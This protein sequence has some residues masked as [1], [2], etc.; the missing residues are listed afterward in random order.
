MNRR[1]VCRGLLCACAAPVEPLEPRGPC[2]GDCAA[3]PLTGTFVQPLLDVRDLSVEAWCRRLSHIAEFGIRELFLQWLVFDGVSFLDH[4][5]VG[6]FLTRF[7][8]AAERVGMLVH[9]G[10]VAD[11]Q[12]G[13]RLQED[14][15]A[16]A[17]YLSGLRATSL[18]T[19]RAAF[20]VAG[21]SPAFAGWYVPEEIDDVNWRSAE[22]VELL[23]SH[24]T[25]LC[26]GLQGIGGSK[27][28]SVSSFVTGTTPADRYGLF[29]LRIWLEAPLTVLLQDG[30]GVDVQRWQRLGPYA[31]ALRDSARSTGRRW[32][33][34][35]ELFEQQGG[36]PLDDAAFSARPATFARVAG[37][38]DLARQVGA[39]RL[40]G[41]TVSDYMLNGAHG[42]PNALGQ[43]FIAAYCASLRRP[44]RPAD[45][46][47]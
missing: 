14:P 6:G 47:P 13:L 44:Q 28:V 12:F 10:L 22:R 24:L 31:A 39:G 15:A 26:R 32:D 34:V 45:P 18:E 3:A 11:P 25:A 19:A 20:A 7:L 23:A 46:Q 1:S 43:S 35:V 40:I 33:M 5:G 16:I 4:S 9:L 21:G 42:G 27:E 29:W 37:Q 38:V 17:E 8:A 36:P 30:A 41:F 2:V